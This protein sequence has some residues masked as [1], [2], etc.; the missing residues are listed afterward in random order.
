VGGGRIA[1]REILLATPAIR[2]L[3]RCG[4]THQIPALMQLGLRVG[5]STFNASLGELAR[6]G[7]LTAADAEMSELTRNQDGAVA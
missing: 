4:R 6:A 2:N 5:M 3:L 7:L 1:A